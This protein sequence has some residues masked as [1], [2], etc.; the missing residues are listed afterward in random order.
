M[1]FNSAFKGLNNPQGFVP[2][3][4][5]GVTEDGQEGRNM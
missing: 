1:G 5:I 2:M 4:W 3:N